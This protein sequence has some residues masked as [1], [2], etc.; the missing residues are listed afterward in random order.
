MLNPLSNL[1]IPKRRD[2]KNENCMVELKLR[3]HDVAKILLRLQ[4]TNYSHSV[5][6]DRFPGQRLR[7]FGY[8]Y[9]GT[10]LYIK[11]AIRNKVI[12]VSFHAKS[13]IA[14]SIHTGRQLHVQDRGA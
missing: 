5:D 8:D 6:D 11:I 4:I 10:Q 12:C 2:K 13:L 3:H 1:V 14:L 9:D 7:V